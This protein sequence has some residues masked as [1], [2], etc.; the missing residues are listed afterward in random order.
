[1]K[2]KS[3]DYNSINFRNKDVD[4]FATK[5]GK[6]TDPPYGYQKQTTIGDQASSAGKSGAK[7][8]SNAY[9]NAVSNKMQNMT[10]QEKMKVANQAAKK[11]AEK[12]FEADGGKE[13]PSLYSFRQA[14]LREVGLPT[15]VKYMEDEAKSTYKQVMDLP[16]RNKPKR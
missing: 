14:A 1:M 2:N 11:T 3:M 12:I 5:F 4:R 8:M 13:N 16:N 6:D 10:E 9:L 15:D 7:S